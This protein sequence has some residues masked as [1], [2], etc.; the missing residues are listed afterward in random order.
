MDVRAGQT[1][2]SQKESG[3]LNG[4]DDKVG[5]SPRS[6][7]DR[8]SSSMETVGSPTT[9]SDTRGEARRQARCQRPFPSPTE[10]VPLGRTGIYSRAIHDDV[11]KLIRAYEEKDRTDFPTFS[12]IWEEQE[13]S[14]IHFGCGER[15]AREQFMSVLYERFLEYLAPEEVFTAQVGAIYGLYLLYFTQPTIFKKVPIRLNIPTWQ[16]MEMLYQLGFEYDITDLIFI[17]HKLRQRG[18]F[19][20]VAQNTGITKELKQESQ[21]LRDRTEKALIRMEKK[22]NETPFVPYH[23]MLTDLKTIASRYIQVKSDIVSVSLARRASEMV[24]ARLIESNPSSL[25]LHGVKPIPTFLIPR[26]PSQSPQVDDDTA[27]ISANNAIVSNE[28]TQD[29]HDETMN[30]ADDEPMFD[31][32]RP[33][34]TFED[35]IASHRVTSTRDDSAP[36]SNPTPGTSY[37]PQTSRHTVAGP[38]LSEQIS[39]IATVPLPSVF[40][41]SI[42]QASTTIFPVYVEDISRRYNQCRV[43]RQEFAAAGGLP[44]NDYKFP[45]MPAVRKEAAHSMITIPGVQVIQIQAMIV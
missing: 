31:L 8:E 19:V 35:L 45:Q 44:Q 28:P 7:D 36:E 11:Q 29:Q 37:K 39:R 30:C 40:P 26:P 4:A 1:A 10:C 27:M 41:Q 42:L 25:D 15:I 14:M 2:R 24:M 20:Y 12:T 17:I 5:S 6:K 18:A 16:N 43:A 22:M 3:A 38:K 9:L 21:S 23:T 13:F 32:D 34:P 33:L